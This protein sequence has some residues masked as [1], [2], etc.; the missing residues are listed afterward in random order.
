MHPGRDRRFLHLLV[1]AGARV[2]DRPFSDLGVWPAELRSEGLSGRPLLSQCGQAW[3]K[4][5]GAVSVPI[6]TGI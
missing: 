5:S 6:D 1:A 4:G 3:N 2:S